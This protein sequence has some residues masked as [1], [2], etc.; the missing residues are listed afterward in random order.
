[1]LVS[2]F[3]YTLPQELIAQNPVPKR[4]SSRLMLLDRAASTIEHRVFH[5]LPQLLEPGDL[6]VLNDTRVFPARLFGHRGSGGKVEA[7]VL[8][9][10]PDGRLRTLLKAG[11]KI[12]P[13][14]VL[15]LVGDSIRIRTLEQDETGAWFFEPVSNSFWEKLEQCGEVPLPPYISR[16]YSP[17]TD[18]SDDRRRYQTVFARESGSAAAPT[19]GL[20]FT[21]E[22]LDSLA[23]REIETRFLT[24]HIGYE[25]FRPV[26]Q[27]KVEEHLMHSEF[28]S[29]PRET[30]AA[31]ET[32]KRRNR[33]VVAVGTTTC[34]VL[35][36][37]AMMNEECAM[38][39]EETREIPDSSCVHGWTDI[40]IHPGF[41]FKAV[42]AM[43]TNFH[44]PRSTLLM[45]VAAFAGTAKILS[46]YREAVE[47]R[48]RFYSYGDA[49]LI[50]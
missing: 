28:Y 18:R 31:I 37:I 45:L 6:L 9:K 1:M 41:E 44:L 42:D 26:K 15:S 12:L 50:I 25:T 19:A 17:G 24:L 5:E 11:G 23:R 7:L 13:G 29:V 27:E 4:D 49:M 21:P 14:E 43:I 47:L 3:D 10:S 34:R 46:A 33:R 2:E 16:D 40:F 39:N 22:V 35:E 30:L 36:T 8:G 32:A 20:H 38:K 48:Y